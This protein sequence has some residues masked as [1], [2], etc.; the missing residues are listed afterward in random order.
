[1]PV[2]QPSTFR[3]RASALAK[4]SVGIVTSSFASAY[5]S[6][7]VEAA[8][9]YLASQ[10]VNVLV[11]S[12][13]HTRQSKLDTCAALYDYDCHG[14]IIHADTLTDE[15]LNFV[16]KKFPTAVLV[17]HH[18]PLF[19]ERC[20]AVDNALGGEIAARY[21]VS[22]GHRNIAMVRG[23]AQYLEADERSRGFKTALDSL[24]T[25]LRIELPGDFLQDSGERAMNQLHAEHPDVTAVFFHNDEMAFGALK[26]CRRLGIRVPD[27]LSV[28]GFDGIP[29]CEYLSPKLTTVKQ[30][31]R[32]MGE[33][34]AKIVCDLLQDI[35]P[36]DRTAGTTF[37]PVL[38]EHESVSPPAGHHADRVALTQRDTECLTWTAL[39]KTSWEI[40]VILGFSES[41][42]TFHLRN[43]G[44]KLKASNRANAV[45][46]AIHLGLIEFSDY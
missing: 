41:T 39:G 4:G 44:N 40:S 26:E 6:V 3:Q 10:N 23:R 25:E 38:A 13:L 7:L 22:Q 5:Y 33:H 1:M 36:G 31:L 21:L 34:A 16:M 15:A 42:A 20:V 2:D 8:S 11:Q 12:N 37:L 18:L 9:N 24:N 32:Q 29:I 28:I 45:A 43:A 35:A 46:K 14:L 19:S 17:N 30:P 27:D